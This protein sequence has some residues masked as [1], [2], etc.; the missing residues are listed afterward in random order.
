MNFNIIKKTLFLVMLFSAVATPF[1]NSFLLP[2]TRVKLVFEDPGRHVL[3]VFK[4]ATYTAYHKLDDGSA[5]ITHGVYGVLNDTYYIIFSG[6]RFAH[7][8][9][10]NAIHIKEEL[11]RG[12]LTSDNPVLIFKVKYINNDENV[13]SEKNAI[14]RY[15]FPLSDNENYFY[16][17]SKIKKI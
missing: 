12:F 9:K 3:I 8:D 16:K 14:I 2:E 7:I 1:V 4:D 5:A 17:E 6:R 10:T 13:D 11:K 15:Y